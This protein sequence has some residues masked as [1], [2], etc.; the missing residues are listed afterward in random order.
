MPRSVVVVVVVGGGGGG[1]GS[2]GAGGGGGG[3]GGG[4]GVHFFFSFHSPPVLSTPLHSSRSPPTLLS[5]LLHFLLSFAL[6][7]VPLLCSPLLSRLPIKVTGPRGT[8]SPYWLREEHLLSL[9]M[10]QSRVADA[11]KLKL[12]S[13]CFVLRLQS[14]IPALLHT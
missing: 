5:T 6:H 12:G 1:G 3:A 4:G 8:R 9:Q 13:L 11:R 7:C 2:G 10:L 14:D